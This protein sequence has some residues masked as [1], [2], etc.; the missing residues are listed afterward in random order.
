MAGSADVVIT[1]TGMLTHLGDGPATLAAI[2]RGEGRPFQTYE[3]AAQAGCRCTR[4]GLIDRADLT[5]EVLGITRKQ[6][7]FMGPASRMALVAAKEALAEAALVD[8]GELAV[9]VGSGTGDTAAHIESQG[10]LGI[11]GG[12]RRVKPTV[13]P[14]LMASTVSAN[15]VHCLRARGPSA[16]VAAACAG[17]A[18]NVVVAAMLVR[19][20]LAPAALAGGTES[21][22]LHF[23]S[24]FDRMRAYCADADG[25]DANASRPYA[26]DRAGF[27]FGEGAGVLVLERRDRA[28]ARGARIIGVLRGWGLSSDGNG[29]MVQPSADGAFR[30]MSQALATAGLSESD[31]AYVNTHA[32]STPAGDVEEVR[33]LRRRFPAGVRYS[34]TKGFTGHMVSAAGSVEAIVT[35]RLLGEGVA[36]GCLN[37]HPLDP[38]LA[39]SP[40]LLETVPIDGAVA[41]SN[42]FG[43]GGT[44]ACLVLGGP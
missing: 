28:E 30:A 4:V 43:F 13:V 16:S 11:D 44:N 3:P 26:A 33:A 7:R 29:E 9:V 8:D 36:P 35:V 27:I 2:R 5:D 34:S 1:G 22:D 14:R 38:D 18:W 32:T 25:S 40:P 20:G 23:H 6:G 39:D 37:A 24:G 41:M 15:L 17:G 12:A 10:R 31:I 21:V 42:S 19:D